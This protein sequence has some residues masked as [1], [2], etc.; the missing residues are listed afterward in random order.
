MR[1]SSSRIRPKTQ[2]RPSW[3]KGDPPREKRYKPGAKREQYMKDLLAERVTGNSVRH[4]VTAAMKAGLEWEPT[5]KVEY[6]LWSG[7]VIMPCET[8]DHPTI[9]NFAATPDGLLGRDAVLEI[10]CPTSPV[11]VDWVIAGVV[12]EMHRPQMLAQLACTRRRYAMFVAFDP[13]IRDKSKRLFVRKFEP[14]ALEIQLVESHAV[15]FLR[16][17]EAMFRRFTTTEPAVMTRMP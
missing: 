6:E 15:Q 10:K 9:E 17:L 8:I 13:T 16:E 5:A 4:V 12:P 14:D 7:E 11:Y 3:K 2:T 1:C